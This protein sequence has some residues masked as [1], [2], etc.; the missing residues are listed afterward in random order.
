MVP[1]PYL[2]VSA[3]IF[4]ISFFFGSNPKARIAIMSPTGAASR[5]LPGAQQSAKAVLRGKSTAITGLP[6]ETNKSIKKKKN[7]RL[8]LKELGKEEQSPN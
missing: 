5:D 7:Q 4:L 8:H 3:I 6:Q 2:S 1:I